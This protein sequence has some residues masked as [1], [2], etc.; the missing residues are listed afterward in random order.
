MNLNELIAA[1]ASSA[2]FKPG[3]T[4]NSWLDISLAEGFGA[5][6]ERFQSR[7][8]PFQQTP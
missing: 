2:L 3:E 5:N 4:K 8:T 1:K 6:R 7:G